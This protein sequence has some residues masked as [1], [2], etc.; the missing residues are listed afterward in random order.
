[1]KRIC[2]S[3]DEAFCMV[4]PF[5][6]KTLLVFIFSCE[7]KTLKLKTDEG[8]GRMHSQ[9]RG[10]GFFSRD[11]RPSRIFALRFIIRFNHIIPII[12]NRSTFSHLSLIK[13]TPKMIRLRIYPMMENI[14]TYPQ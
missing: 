6:E 1:M 10:D 7:V 3:I 14:R 8:R 4:S 12:H 2:T 13:I 5:A 11:V 9:V